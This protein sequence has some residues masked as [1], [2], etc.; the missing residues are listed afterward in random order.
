M[1]TLSSPILLLL[2]FL[3]MAAHSVETDHL[4]GRGDTRYH[5]IKSADFG[6]GLHV[7]VILP[8]GYSDNSRETYPTIYLT[9]IS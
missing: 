7:Y 2:C 9:T 4:Q 8:D 1:K 5:K 6:W 3:A